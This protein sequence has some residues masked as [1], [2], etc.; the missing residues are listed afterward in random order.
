M[1]HKNIY[2]LII[3]IK[4]I[5]HFNCILLLF[6]HQ[7]SAEN[8]SKINSQNDTNVEINENILNELK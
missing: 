5:C 8:L 4:Y 1:S 3:F 7:K 6:F 2:Q